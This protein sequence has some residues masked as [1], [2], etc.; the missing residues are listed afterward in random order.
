MVKTSFAYLSVAQLIDANLDRAKE[1]LRVVEDWCRF[2]LHREDFIVTLKDWRQKLGQQHHYK[3][4]QARSTT[5][6]KGIGLDHPAQKNRLTPEHVISANCARVQEALRVIEEFA[7]SSNPSLASISAKIRYGLYQLEIDILKASIG[8]HRRQKLA[9][10]KICLITSPIPDLYKKVSSALEAGVGMVQYRYKEGKDLQKLTEAKKLN[11]LCK[12]HE[13]LF[14]IN[15]RIDLALAVN[16]DGVHLGQEDIPTETA[17]SILGEEFLLG[18]STHCLDELKQAEQEGCDYLGVG[19]INT[20]STKPETN[21]VGIS[22]AALAS[23]STFLPWF[24]IGGINSS[25]VK[26]I[27]KAGATRIAVSQAIMC[28]KNPEKATQELIEE[29]R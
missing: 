23:Q 11:N 3:Y 20:T 16:A 1:G 10:C 7:R 21:S 28:T 18:R 12:A 29:L 9:S 27:K 8:A 19:P 22:F 15:D 6:D 13:A 14:V 5:T 25:N 2:G 26:I 24:A 17:R 4:K